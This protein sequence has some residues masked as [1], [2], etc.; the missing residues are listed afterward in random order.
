MDSLREKIQKN[1]EKTQR[2]VDELRSDL[3]IRLMAIVPHKSFYRVLEVSKAQ[4]TKAEK[5]PDLIK[6]VA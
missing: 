5:S 1:H 6:Q 4:T 3:S 2:L